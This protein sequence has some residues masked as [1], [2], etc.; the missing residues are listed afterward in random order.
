M[1][2]RTQINRR[3]P[4]EHPVVGMSTDMCT[5]LDTSDACFRQG[6][7]RRYDT[8]RRSRHSSHFSEFG[9]LGRYLTNSWAG[10]G[11]LASGASPDGGE[12]V[13]QPEDAVVDADQLTAQRVLRNARLETRA[14]LS[15]QLPSNGR[16][17]CCSLLMPV[18]CQRKCCERAS[19]SLK[20]ASAHRSVFVGVP[21]CPHRLSLSLSAE[22]GSDTPV[23]ENVQ[24]CTGKNVFE[25]VFAST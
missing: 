24:V 6:L 14:E 1:F 8:Q 2:V 5:T 3:N 21:A 17:H 15:D 16:E 22:L 7:L 18:Q 10:P 11:L 25:S 20:K 9:P 4:S 23:S 13:E 12:L 19:L